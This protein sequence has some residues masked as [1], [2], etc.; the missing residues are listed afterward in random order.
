L[1]KG[2]TWTADATLVG[3]KKIDDVVE[4]NATLK[5]AKDSTAKG[6]TFVS[7]SVSGWLGWGS[8]KP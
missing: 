8:K 7:T 4:K 2:Y 5:A 3:V 1:K 6:I